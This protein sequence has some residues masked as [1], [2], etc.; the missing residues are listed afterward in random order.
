LDKMIHKDFSSRPV[1][2]AVNSVKNN[3]PELI[4]ES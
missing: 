3:S 1:S 4:Q 2:K